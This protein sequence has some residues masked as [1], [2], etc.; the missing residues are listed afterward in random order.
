MVKLHK[1]QATSTTATFAL[2]E[3]L[4]THQILGGGGGGYDEFIWGENI[5][6]EIP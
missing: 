1:S 6:Y 5:F 3:S 2:L 4:G